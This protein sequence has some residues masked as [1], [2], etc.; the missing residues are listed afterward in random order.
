MAR[1]FRRYNS[2]IYGNYRK[3]YAIDGLLTGAAMAAVTFLRDLLA[4]APM[5]TPENYVSELVLAVGIFWS[6]Y[7]YRRQLPDQQVTLKELMLLG[8]GIGIV[9]AVVYGLWVWLDAACVNTTLVQHYN[10]Q[11]IAVMPAA[12]ESAEARVAIEQ[13]RR[14]TAGDW[15]FISGFRSAVMSIILAFFAALI[16]RTEKSPVVVK[17]SKN[18]TN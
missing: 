3:A 1:V 6:A 11:R 12:D 8:I 14:Y 17:E 13:V 5:A 16:F 4:A 15:G 2:T 9:S 18:K 10:E 7:Q